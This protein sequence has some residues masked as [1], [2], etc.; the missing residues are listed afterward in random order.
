MKFVV[1][2]GPLNE[3]DVK[4]QWE[5]KEKLKKAFYWGLCMPLSIFGVYHFVT[6]DHEKTP[7]EN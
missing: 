7:D 4:L 5:T 2:K 3:V 6:K 1:S